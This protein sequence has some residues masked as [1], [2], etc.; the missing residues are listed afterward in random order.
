MPPKRKTCLDYYESELESE[1]DPYT[2]PSSESESESESEPEL[3]SKSKSKPISKPISKSDPQPISKSK[4]R[5]RTLTPKQ[6]SQVYSNQNG[7]CANNPMYPATGLKDYK[8]LLWMINDGKFDASGCQYDH[9]D[10]HALGGQATIEN[11]QALCPNCHA[12]KTA[13]FRT[14]KNQFT[15]GEIDD[16]RAMMQIDSVHVIKKSR[17]R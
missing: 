1:S 17:Y 9:K 14:H 11:T 13:K 6:K 4:P 15:T 2:D 12:Y 5:P 3:K 8:C 7:K 16:G 10:E